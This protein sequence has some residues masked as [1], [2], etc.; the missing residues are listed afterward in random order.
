M[1]WSVAER[2][3]PMRPLSPSFPAAPGM[4]MMERMRQQLEIE[5][6][7][8]LTRAAPDF[9]ALDAAAA[10]AA[11]LGGPAAPPQQQRG[12]GA[13]ATATS[14]RAAWA[15]ARVGRV[16]ALMGELVKHAELLQL[17][18]G[19]VVTQR[20]GALLL[21]GSLQCAPDLPEEGSDAARDAVRWLCSAGRHQ[22]QGLLPAMWEVLTP[23]DIA[24]APGGSGA[25]G[26]TGPLL[27]G[28]I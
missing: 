11:A 2:S 12:A 27:L 17:A 5:A 25:G 15:R 3:P 7:Q 24:A 8:A 13:G 9:A 26:R 22:G 28:G 18:P 23:E 19:A 1:R 10:A 4:L 21:A 16:F 20:T 6:T 14:R